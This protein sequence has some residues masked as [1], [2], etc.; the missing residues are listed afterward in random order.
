[1]VYLEVTKYLTWLHYE[2]NF[3]YM[4]I[5]Y[6]LSFI[7][8]SELNVQKSVQDS[9]ISSGVDL[10]SPDNAVLAT[11]MCEYIMKSRSV[12]TSKKYISSFSRWSKFIANKGKSAIP[13]NPFHISLYLTHLLHI[14]CSFHVISS[15]VY[16][17]KWAH[18]ILGHKDPTEHSFIKN[19]LEASKRNN[20]PKV[21]KK[22]IV[23]ASDLILLCDIYVDS[24]NLL[25]VRDLCMI[26]L[27]FA[28]FLRFEELSSLRC[29]DLTF[30]D[31]YVKISINKSKTDQYRQGNEILI[32]AGVTSACPV[33]MLNRY[34]SLGSIDISSGHFLFKSVFKSKDG[35]KLIYKDKKLSYTRARECILSK[36]KSVMGNINIGLHS[37]RSGGA[38][39]AANSKVNERCWKKHGRWASDSSKDGYVKDSLESRLSVSKNLG[40]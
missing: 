35:L 10:S 5:I 11:K 6:N 1:M 36:L 16:A 9:L 19:L 15:A 21:I 34:I 37:L 8:F 24:T 39:A 33:K 17:I 29:S 4:L 18:S 22:A 20:K 3:R 40:L 2:S 28:G 38:T 32:S 30:M 27:S 31:G 12:N 7:Y 25:E 23:T 13:A 14:G 26:L